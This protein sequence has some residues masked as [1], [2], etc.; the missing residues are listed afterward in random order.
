MPKM[1]GLELQEQLKSLGVEIP[2]I[3]MT[4]YP[5]DTIRARALNAGAIA[6]LD[7]RSDLGG[8][9][10]ND[11]IFAAINGKPGSTKPD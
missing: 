5:D 9:S 2:I 8:Q 3:F 11:W 6:F 7:K 10:L 1:T 4:A